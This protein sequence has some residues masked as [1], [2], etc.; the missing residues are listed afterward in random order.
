MNN[1]QATMVG[2][3]LDFTERLE[4]QTWIAD[5]QLWPKVKAYVIADFLGV[6]ED[7]VQRL[8]ITRILRC[9]PDA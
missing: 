2:V 1:V 5:M 9:A 8:I 4:K 7:E 6:P 3:M